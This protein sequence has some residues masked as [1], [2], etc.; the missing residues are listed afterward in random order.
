MPCCD[1]Q[2]PVRDLARRLHTLL[3][4]IA[5]VLGPDLALR[6]VHKSHRLLSMLA[7]PAAEVQRL[8]ERRSAYVDVLGVPPRAGLLAASESSHIARL[9]QQAFKAKLQHFADK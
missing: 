1:L 5:P 7:D 8:Q 9:S 2:V 3:N 6:Y 4:G